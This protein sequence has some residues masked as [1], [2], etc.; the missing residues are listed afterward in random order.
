MTMTTTRAEATLTSS[1]PTTSSTRKGGLAIAGI[2][3]ACALA[4]SLPLIVGA[5][6]FASVGAFA[7]GTPWVAIALLAVA[8]ASAAWWFRRRRTAMAAAAPVRG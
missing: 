5:G 8:G 3:A 2:A 4:C 1:A 6:L 7:I